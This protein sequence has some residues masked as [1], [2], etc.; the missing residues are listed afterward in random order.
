MAPS[1]KPEETFRVLVTGFGVCFYSLLGFS[2]RL[3]PEMIAV[4]ALQRKSLLA[5]SQT[6]AE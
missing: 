1:V 2:Q 6:S 5:R 4:W 3:I